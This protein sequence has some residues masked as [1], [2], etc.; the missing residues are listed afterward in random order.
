MTPPPASAVKRTR[1]PWGL[2]VRETVSTYLPLLFM[3]ALA[4]FTWWL[5]R[6][7]P[8]PEVSEPERV[9][10]HEPDYTMKGVLLQRFDA[11]GV[12]R[13]EVSGDTLRHYPDDDTV[14][15]DRVRIRSW[16]RDQRLGVATAER[17]VTTS[18][19]TELRLHGGAQVRSE[20]GPGDAQALDFASEFLHVFIDERKLRTHL[21][22]TL[23][24]GTND[25]RAAGLEYT[26]ETQVLVLQGPLRAQLQPDLA[27][28]RTPPR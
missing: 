12:L 28:R 20:A 24:L 13:V 6:H 10:R 26:E 7:T 5:A 9:L 18:S 11:A 15:V 22:V 17:A 21:P 16:G 3:V 27:L 4:L 2:R 1:A 19:A 14:E 8:Q 25:V 23:R